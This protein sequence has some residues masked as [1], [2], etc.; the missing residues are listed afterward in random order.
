MLTVLLLF[1]YYCSSTLNKKGA[2]KPN[3][4]SLNKQ[5]YLARDCLQKSS[6]LQKET[7]T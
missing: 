6:G 7:K 2:Q 4:R 3:R 5:Y 1:I